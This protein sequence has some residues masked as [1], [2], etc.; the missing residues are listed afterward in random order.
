MRRLL[1]FI[2]YAMLSIFG[3]ALLITG[4]SVAQQP[5]SGT[6]ISCM[7][8][9]IG[10]LLGREGVPSSARCTDHRTLMVTVYKSDGTEVTDFGNGTAP[11]SP[12]HY[13]ITN[14]RC[15]NSGSIAGTSGAVGGVTC[16][17]GDF[18]GTAVDA[19]GALNATLSVWE[20]GTGSGTWSL[21][22]CL[23][24]PGSGGTIT[25]VDPPG[26]KDP[27]GTPTPAAPDPLCTKINMD[28]AGAEVPVNG[29]TPHKF[30]LAAQ[31]FNYLVVRT[32]TCTGNCDATLSVQVRF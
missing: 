26:S 4:L 3:A 31:T 19:R 18:F 12:G 5:M 13:T 27:A 8:D 24:S 20:Y 28:Q 23:D 29:I 25:G 7:I 21:W 6:L 11:I 16:A 2:A 15:D 32:D 1:R 10:T 17:A 9:N 14:F 22:D 30:N